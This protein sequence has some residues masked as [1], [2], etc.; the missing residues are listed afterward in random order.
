[1][2]GPDETFI[3]EF[4]DEMEIDDPYEREAIRD[5]LLSEDACE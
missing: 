5:E 4:L 2:I 3:E 1:M